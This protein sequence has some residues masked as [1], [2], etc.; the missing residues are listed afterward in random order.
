MQLLDPARFRGT[1]AGEP[2]ALYVLKNSQ[3][4]VACITNYGAKIEQLVVPDRHGVFADVVLGYGSLDDAVAGAPS[5]GAFIGRYAGRIENAAFVFGATSYQ[6]NANDGPHCL[7]GGMRGSRFTVFDAVH[8]DD[9]SVEMRYVFADGE[10]GFPG[11]LELR[12][13]YTVTEANE[14]VI[15][16]QATAMDKPT[17]ASF[18]THAYFN[19]NGEASGS[20]LGHEV[21][22]CADRYFAMNTALIATGQLLPVADTPFDFRRATV[23]DTR[24]GDSARVS[25][26]NLPG[27]QSVDG[28]DCCY[29]TNRRAGSTDL[30]L[31]ARACA[32][33]SGRVMEVWSTEPALQFYTGL[34]AQEALPGGPG[35]TGARYFQQQSLCFEP[36]AY[37]NAPNLPHFPSALYVPGVT[38]RGKTVY[39]FSTT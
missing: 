28:Y 38:C 36:Q 2:V 39:R 33:E 20:A 26:G 18:T 34:V 6:L 5:L 30:A 3:G 16:Y 7:H 19:L 27:S 4:M 31:A 1:L 35:K 8:C 25:A 13:V 15:D 32:P 29:L 37:P 10:E 17:V 14:L 11:M 12:L 23:L 21:M 22:I 24:V 9:S